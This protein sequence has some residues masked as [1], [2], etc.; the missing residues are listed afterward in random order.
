[1]FIVSKESIVN[2]CALV[3]EQEEVCNKTGG[4]DNYAHNHTQI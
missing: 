2:M 3:K 4:T 1:M